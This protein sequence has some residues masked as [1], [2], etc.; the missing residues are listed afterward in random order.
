[1]KN[2]KKNITIKLNLNTNKYVILLLIV[3]SSSCASRKDLVYFQDEPLDES[4]LFSN[5]YELTFKSDDLLTIDISGL[6][7]EAVKPVNLPAVS[8]DV[9]SVI[10]AQGRLKMQTY[11]ID[12]EENIEFPV[13]GTMKIGGLTRAQTTKLFKEKLSE[14]I[15]NPIVN[16]RLA[17]F[18]VTVLGEVARPGT[19]TIQDERISLPEALGLAG[20]L[21]IYGKRNNIFLIREVNGKKRFAKL[22]LTSINIVNSPLYYLS[23]ND[24]IVVEPNKARIRQSTYNQNNGVIISAIGVLA[25][26]AAILIK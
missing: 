11:L 5:N 1:M 14:Y 17:N 7:P 8:Y 16:I 20:D 22:D 3:L 9:S 15:T 21:T 10:S 6:E 23:Q 24:V 2:F 12:T 25:T 26:V 13:L 4:E 18:T 19:F